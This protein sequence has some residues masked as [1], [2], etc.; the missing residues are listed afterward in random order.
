VVDDE[1]AAAAVED[2]VDLDPL[3]SQRLAACGQRVT[4]PSQ[5]LLGGEQFPAGG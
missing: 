4:R 3:P 1:L 5:L 2:V